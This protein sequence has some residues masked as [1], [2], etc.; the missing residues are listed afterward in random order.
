MPIS[1]PLVPIAVR[2]H[3]K[4]AGGAQYPDFNQLPAEKRGGQVWSKYIDNFGGWHYDKVDNLGT[5]FAEGC[6]ICLVP[7]AF[8]E[9]ARIAFSEDVRVLTEAEW[10]AFHDDRCHAHDE[11]EIL[12]VEVLQG[13]QARLALE[14]DPS[15]PTADAR[16]EIVALR[17][18]M[19]DPKDP[20]RGIRE[21][22]RRFW[23]R[24]KV[25]RDY[26]ID[27][28]YTASSTAMSPA[29]QRSDPVLGRIAK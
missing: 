28:T 15:A 16:A 26:V 22:P 14:A 18:R 27:A 2:I 23:V 4:S 29:E 20:K 10:A 25:D 24:L 3:R 8:A 9:A 12:D 11:D 1:E 5:G 6:G 13:L 21:N 17:T 19:L 7:K